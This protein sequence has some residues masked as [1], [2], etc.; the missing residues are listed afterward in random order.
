MIARAGILSL[1]GFLFVPGTIDAHHSVGATFDVSSIIEVEGNVTAIRWRNPH[2]SFTVGVSE[3]NGGEELW[4]IESNSVS[5]L[6][7]MNVSSDVL[8][9]GERVRVAGN[10]GRQNRNQLYARNLLLPGTEEVLMSPGSEPRWAGETI[11]T[12]E[13]WFADS[14]DGSDPARGI[15]RVWS[16][17]LGPRR[18][19]LGFWNENYPLTAAARA[20]VEAYDPVDD[21]PILNC[22]PKGMPTIMEQPYP[23]EFVEQDQAILLRLEEYDTVRTIHMGA[24]PD[25]V[26]RPST[27]L[28]HSVGRWEDRTLVV[29]TTDISWGYFSTVLGIP[30]SDSVEIEERFTPSVD[31]SRLNYTMR[32][33]DPATF[34]EPVVLEK[35]WLWL[36]D[37]QVEPYECTVSG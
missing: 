5:I 10:P 22:A 37:A 15:F 9:V 6:R 16:T 27:D 30:H 29:A 3:D 2:V 36:S 11:G 32:I 12:S 17:P 33:T 18:A 28:G 35:Y 7:R 20:A 4:E 1:L 14:G 21:S 23:L 26:E 8:R 31:G 24:E 19:G 25:R 34:T 13:T